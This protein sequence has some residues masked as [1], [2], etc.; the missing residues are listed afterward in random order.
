MLIMMDVDM[1][2]KTF[3]FFFNQNRFA[4]QDPNKSEMFYYMPCQRL[5]TSNYCKTLQSSTSM[6]VRTIFYCFN[7]T[8][9]QD[10]PGYCG[11]T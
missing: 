6:A 1:M 2:I 7:E 10:F 8:R 5:D 11:C 9:V 3:F 4:V